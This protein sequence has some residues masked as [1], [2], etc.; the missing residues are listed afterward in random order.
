MGATPVPG[1]N[2]D[3]KQMTKPKPLP[4]NLAELRAEYQKVSDRGTVI[5]RALNAEDATPQRQPSAIEVAAH[6]TRETVAGT[7]TSSNGKS[8]RDELGEVA[9]RKQALAIAIRQTQQR[10]T[11]K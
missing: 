11:S 2:T 6:H 1:G 8:L 4:H 9:Q 10:L 5:L 7:S 3:E